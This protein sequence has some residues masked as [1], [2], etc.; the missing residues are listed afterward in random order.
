MP[1][2]SRTPR[3]H[4]NEDNDGAI[5]DSL[6]K[7][8]DKDKKK[9]KKKH[10]TRSESAGE[11]GKSGSEFSEHGKKKKKNKSKHK[12]KDKKKGKKKEK[13]SNQN[14]TSDEESENETSDEDKWSA[15]DGDVNYGDPTIL[16]ECTDEWACR[17]QEL[18]DSDNPDCPL[19]A[20]HIQSKPRLV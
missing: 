17:S 20:Y 8:Q 18:Y 3:K 14:T 12:K 16:S 10:R 9:R 5:S 15:N 19:N 2:L 6:K 11:E 1:K 4:Y 13:R 7:S